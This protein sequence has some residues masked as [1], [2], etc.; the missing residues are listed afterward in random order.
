MPFVAFTVL[1]VVLGVTATMLL[2]RHVFLAPT[3]ASGTGTP[4]DPTEE[5][6]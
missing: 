1:Y 4:T 2:R 5:V 6:A 3:G